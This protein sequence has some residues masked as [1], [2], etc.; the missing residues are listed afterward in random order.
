MAVAFG[1]SRA[2]AFCRMTTQGGAQV[3]SQACVERGEFLE[4]PTSC[5]A[6]AIDERGSVWMDFADVERAVDTA[7]ATWSS[8]TCNGEPVDLS[9]QAYQSSTCQRAEFR[10]SGNVNTVAFRDPWEDQCGNDYA[11]N[12]F[13]VTVVWHDTSTGRILDAD[14]MINERLGP[15]A[16]CPDSGCPRG[17]PADP[18]PAD[19]Q[20]IVT[21][22]AGHFIGIGH[23][24]DEE[25]TMFPSSSR[26]DV[27][28]RDLA[29]DDIAAVCTIF[30]PGGN[31]SQCEPSTVG[32][33]DLDCEDDGP[34]DCDGNTPVP[35]SSNGCSTSNVGPADQTGT[36][37]VV[38]LVSLMA[39]WRRRMRRAARR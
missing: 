8:Q 36:W 28:K 38:L 7:F 39:L 18:G 5:L 24:D 11:V 4:W 34:P 32:G 9:F 25:A 27:S 29:D 20:S 21:H 30:P 1:G 15:Y 13:A 19:L 35:S 6:Y 33:L 16:I 10:S 14:M 37:L 12:A 31:R 3:G 2:S 26:V 22:E 23:S 17:T